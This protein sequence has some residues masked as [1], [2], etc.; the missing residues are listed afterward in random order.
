MPETTDNLASLLKAAIS[1]HEP[2]L[3]D[4]QKNYGLSN[5]PALILAPEGMKPHDLKPYLDA[6]RDRPLRAKGVAWMADLT[7]LILLCGRFK[8]EDAAH[9]ALFCS[10]DAKAPSLTAIFNYNETPAE[11]DGPV[12]P[13]FGDHRAV[14]PFPLSE[15]WIAWA[16]LEGQKTS[17][18]E[19]AAFLEARITDVIF[20]PP[21][22][23]GGAA[24]ADVAL[25]GS[26]S[27]QPKPGAG[28]DFGPR[29]L[30]EDLAAYLR[31]TGGRVGGPQTI[32][33]LSRGLELTATSKMAQRRNL[34][35][36]EDAISFE[37]T[38]TDKAG[39][40]VKVPA[41]FLIS[42]P[43]FDGGESY[44]MAVKLRYRISNG[45]VVWFFNRARVKETFEAAIRQAA[46]HAAAQTSLPLF[47]G[48]PESS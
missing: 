36:G 14:Y 11:H 28:G 43:V 26:D 24:P 30:E 33:E 13:G 17:Q 39:A 40:P 3:Y 19:F 4:L 38:H 15:A 2:K 34:Q 21:S 37:E 48:A 27:D 31:L 45:T 41:V 47:Y 8:N 46:Q 18:L 23:T 9:A 29:S 22:L 16:E 5:D 1:H 20:P 7:S 25:I 44:L 35:S 12:L 6:Y 32:A 10:L 42:I